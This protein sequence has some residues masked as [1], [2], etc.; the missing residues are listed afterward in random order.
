MFK[1]R[2]TWQH[3]LMFSNHCRS[4]M[5]LKI[6]LETGSS[7]QNIEKGKQSPAWASHVGENEA[8]PPNGLHLISVYYFTINDRDSRL[9]TLWGHECPSC[10]SALWTLPSSHILPLPHIYCTESSTFLGHRGEIKNW[11]HFVVTEV[12]LV[13]VISQVWATH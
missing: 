6:F 5:G 9:I 3:N 7:N 10:L 1:W 12:L 4:Y 2:V 13:C 11:S 8:K